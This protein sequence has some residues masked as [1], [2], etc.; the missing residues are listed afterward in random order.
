MPAHPAYLREL[1]CIWAFAHAAMRVQG[2]A[3]HLARHVVLAR[4][5]MPDQEGVDIGGAKIGKD[6]GR[7]RER[8]DRSWVAVARALRRFAS[9]ARALSLM[10]NP[11][12]SSRCGGVETFLTLIAIARLSDGRRRLRDLGLRWYPASNGR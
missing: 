5:L 6:C 3:R 11:P 1:L 12:P 4:Q 7:T 8:S 10:M 9:A 2:R